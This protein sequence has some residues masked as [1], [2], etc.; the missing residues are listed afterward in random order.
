[1][2][3]YDPASALRYARLVAGERLDP[4]AHDPENVTPAY[5]KAAKR[6][7]AMQASEWLAQAMEPAVFA[8]YERQIVALMKGKRYVPRY[9]IGLQLGL[10]GRA[11]AIHSV[12]FVRKG[13]A[14]YLAVRV[15]ATP[16]TC[17]EREMALVQTTPDD[18]SQVTFD[19]HRSD[20]WAE[21]YREKFGQDPPPLS[22]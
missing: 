9:Q 6:Q 4:V 5:V 15:K 21:L 8:D 3:T 16:E 18:S 2:L 20:L 10:Y 11:V 22:E 7:V 12:M 14:Y 13:S 1:M 19:A 17:Q